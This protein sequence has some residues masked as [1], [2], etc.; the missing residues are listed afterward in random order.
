MIFFK[1]K[2][3]PIGR[4]EFEQWSNKIIAKAN[5][6]AT[7]E[8]QKFTLAAMLL[9]NDKIDEDFYVQKLQK[10]ATEQ[11]AREIMREIKE[12]KIAEEKNNTEAAQDNI[13]PINC[14]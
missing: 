5:F 10:A 1:K 14:S 8:S 7:V 9:T 13:K 4:T 3:L 12:A 11:T 2:R 6:E